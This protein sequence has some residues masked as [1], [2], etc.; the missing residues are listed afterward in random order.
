MF[1]EPA[2]FKL[3]VAEEIVTC[4]R[5]HPGTSQVILEPLEHFMVLSIALVSLPQAEL[6]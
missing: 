2:Y 6:A 5:K 4:R 3:W 1:R